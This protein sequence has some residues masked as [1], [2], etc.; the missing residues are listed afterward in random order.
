MREMQ[1]LAGEPGTYLYWATTSGKSGTRDE[2]ETLLSGAFIV[3]S[4]SVQ[5]KRSYF[6][7]GIW[8]KADME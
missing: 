3:I 5:V 6:V 2:A 4:P 1:F 7:L 8:T